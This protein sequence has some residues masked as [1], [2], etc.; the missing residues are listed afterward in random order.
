MAHEHVF[1]W[2]YDRPPSLEQFQTMFPDDYSCAAYWVVTPSSVTPKNRKSSP[3]FAS[4]IPITAIVHPP[5]TS[6]ERIQDSWRMVCSQTE[7]NELRQ[8]LY[9]VAP[10]RTG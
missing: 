7:A 1:R 6:K 3:S 9:V 8:G 2:K 5:F 4:L 10:E